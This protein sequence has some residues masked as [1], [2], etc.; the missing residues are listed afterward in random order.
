VTA[1]LL[2]FLVAVGLGILSMPV[3]ALRGARRDPDAIRKGAHFLLGVGDFFVHWF[4]WLVSPVERAAVRSGVKPDLFNFL[5]LALGFAAG[6][7]IATGHLG[8]G[9]WAIALGGVCDILDGR[10]ARAMRLDSDYGK[11]IDSTLDRFVEVFAFLGFVVYLRDFAAGPFLVTAAIAGSLLVSYARARGESLDVECKGGLMQR[12]E[13]LALT[14]LVCLLDPVLTPR[15]GLRPGTLV[16]WAIAAIAAGTFG[17]AIYRT[18]TISSRL[19]A[20]SDRPGGASR[21]PG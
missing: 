3:F 13:R 10:V 1:S 21:P 14:W 19:R 15:F 16:L 2:V 4:M 12:A 17:T 9:A 20:R 8:F 11:F 5:G 7:L 18:I 6:L